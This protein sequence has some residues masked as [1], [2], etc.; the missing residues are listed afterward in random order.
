MS[1]NTI[2]A[3]RKFSQEEKTPYRFEDHDIR[4]YNRAG[5]MATV[6]ASQSYGDGAHP[7]TTVTVR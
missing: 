6:I 2:D 5:L 3:A 7:I 4:Y 1:L